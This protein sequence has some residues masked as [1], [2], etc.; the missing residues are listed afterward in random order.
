MARIIYSTT[1]EEKKYI[2]KEVV[3]AAWRHKRWY[4]KRPGLVMTHL[5]RCKIVAAATQG[6]G[7]TLRVMSVTCSNRFKFPIF[8]YEKSDLRNPVSYAC[9]TLRSWAATLRI[10]GIGARSLLYKEKS[11]VI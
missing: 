11:A 8:L 7:N 6:S 9:N 1:I 4:K 2:L 10:R 5:L 3:S